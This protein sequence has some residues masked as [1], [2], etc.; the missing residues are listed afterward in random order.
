FGIGANWDVTSLITRDAKQRA[1]TA[2]SASVELDIAWK[3]WQVAQAAKIAAYDVLALESQLKSAREMNR[4]FDENVSL[5]RHA[6]EKNNKT[7]PDL[8]A[9]D[10][11][12]Q[13]ARESVLAQERDWRHARLLLNRALGVPPETV[14]PLREQRLPSS[15][16][17]PDVEQLLTNMPNHR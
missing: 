14:V 13:D 2:Q 1:A 10:A 7:L 16:T 4:Q 9:A 15:L 11:S 8:S 3:E 12:A 5:V 6:M 17:P